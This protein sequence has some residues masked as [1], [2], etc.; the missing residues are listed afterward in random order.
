[1]NRFISVVG[2]ALVVLFA[3]YSWQ[4]SPS[5]VRGQEQADK[6]E[7]VKKELDALQ[8]TWKFLLWEERGNE[9]PLEKRKFVIDKDKLTYFV[10][11][12]VNAE[13]TFEVDPTKSPKQM[14]LKL[15]S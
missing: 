10:N 14:D 2:I 15:T 5:I 8:G 6:T 7:L 11:D 4:V 1:M 9:R 13:G 12:E 3:F